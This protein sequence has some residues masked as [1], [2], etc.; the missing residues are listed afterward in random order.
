MASFDERTCRYLFKS[1]ESARS[2]VS[3]RAS[4]ICVTEMT[5]SIVHITARYDR[6]LIIVSSLHATLYH[7]RRLASVGDLWHFVLRRCEAVQYSV[8]TIDRSVTL[9]VAISSSHTHGVFSVPQLTCV[10]PISISD[11]C[12]LPMLLIDIYQS[13]PFD[14]TSPSLLSILL[15]LTYDASRCCQRPKHSD[16]V[17][18][19]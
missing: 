17:A 8:I 11:I 7:R 18:P 2:R 15:S 1:V 13:Y 6:I 4:N 14:H 3:L 9:S 19:S 5:S 12:H 10:A 16:L